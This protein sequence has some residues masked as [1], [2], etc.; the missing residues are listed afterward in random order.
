MNADEQQELFQKLGLDT[1]DANQAYLSRIG[2]FYNGHPLVLRV[3]AEEILQPPFQ[4]DVACYWRRYEAEFVDSPPPKTHK[5]ARS[6]QFR[7]RVRQR[8]EQSLQRLPAPARQMLCASAVFRRPVSE[9]FWQAMLADGDAQAPFDTLRDRHLVEYVPATDDQAP[10]RVRQHNLI[11]AVAY[12]LLKADRETW[13]QAERQAAQLWLTDYEP[14][15]NAPNLET[16]RGY[17]EAFEHYYA[18]KDWQAAKDLPDTELETG[19]P[20][21]WQLY[22]W[23]YY[24]ELMVLQSKA[25]TIAREINNPKG[26]GAALKSLGNAYTALEQYEQAID[27]HQQ[28]LSIARE[29]GNRQG[30]VNALNNLGIVYNNLGQYE[31]A[32]D[33]YQQSLTIAREIS[34]RRGEGN[35][36]GNMGATFLKIGQYPASLT[37][38][39]AALEIFRE[40]GDRGNEAEALK[41]L[42]AL[43][44]ALGEIETARRY[45]QQALALATTLGVPLAAECEALGRELGGGE[46]GEF[47]QHEGLA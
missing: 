8:V 44:Q 45:C 38:I 30:K 24:R 16:L 41:N 19:Q 21:H 15:P 22:Y 33:H 6:R 14:A 11:R 17:L 40:I 29:I 23:S 28:S 26:E 1:G 12:D 5:L 32:I 10:L 31:Q 2:A 25:L 36:L 7:R 13:F 4:G 37:H 35:A 27:H 46:A 47:A 3:I 20:L 42:A 43:H 39:R 9:A 34:D 18:V